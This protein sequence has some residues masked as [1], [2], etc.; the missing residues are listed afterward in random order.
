MCC[1]EDEC[2]R[3][4]DGVSCNGL[5]IRGMF[6]KFWLGILESRGHLGYLCVKE[7]II[8]KLSLKKMVGT[9][10]DWTSVDGW[11]V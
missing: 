8:L 7:R 1:Q 9:E 4:E 3:A 10:A 5:G 6:T 2:R 11:V